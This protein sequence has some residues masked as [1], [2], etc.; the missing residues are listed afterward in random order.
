MILSSIERE[1]KYRISNA[2]FP[3]GMNCSKQ[4]VLVLAEWDYEQNCIARDAGLTW[5]RKQWQ[6]Q[7]NPVVI[8]GFESAEDVRRRSEGSLLDNPGIRY[9]QLPVRLTE[10][11]E[12]VDSIREVRP[13]CLDL[14][15][16]KRNIID[17]EVKLGGWWHRFNNL[18]NTIFSGKRK[19][20]PQCGDW[21][22][23]QEWGVLAD[24]NP[25]ILR[26][27]AD[28]FEAIYPQSAVDLDALTREQLQQINIMLSEAA[29]AWESFMAVLTEG[30]TAEGANRAYDQLM[31]LNELLKKADAKLADTRKRLRQLAGGEQ[32]NDD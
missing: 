2:T 13:E 28:E 11:Q 20:S 26:Q 27:Y 22:R 30:Y 9:L 17:F 24:N 21:D 32:P 12:A 10:I 3:S 8:L 7:P 25:R 6:Q 29:T 18:E 5:V 1:L 14:N 4:V 19:L 15:S 31:R 16:R 23:Q